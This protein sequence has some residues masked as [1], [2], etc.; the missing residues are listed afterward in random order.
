MKPNSIDPVHLAFHIV[1]V[2][3]SREEITDLIPENI[4][5]VRML[6]TRALVRCNLRLRSMEQVTRPNV[7]GPAQPNQLGQ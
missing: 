3:Q 4:R 7:F 1:L 5:V 2:N 6:R